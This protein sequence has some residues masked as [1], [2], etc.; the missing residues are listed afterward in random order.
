VDDIAAITSAYCDIWG[1]LESRGN[2]AMRPFRPGRRRN[3]A[4]ATVP[5]ADGTAGPA[6]QPP[7]YEYGSVSGF[8][9]TMVERAT[10][11]PAA[12]TVRPR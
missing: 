7:S 9:A 1:H 5:A 11:V 4:A 2:A 3:P 12:V 10:C 6:G 8:G